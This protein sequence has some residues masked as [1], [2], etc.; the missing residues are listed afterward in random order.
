[1]EN[2]IPYL[3][4][5]TIFLLIGW[6]IAV[7]TR[8]S[9]ILTFLVLLSAG[10]VLFANSAYKEL[11]FRHPFL[12]GYLGLA[13]GYYRNPR[14][15]D[16]SY[17][18]NFSAIDIFITPIKSAIGII[19]I[20]LYL[21]F[22][23][24][25]IFSIRLIYWLI[26]IFKT[27]SSVDGWKNLFWG[28]W[29][30]LIYLIPQEI[31]NEWNNTFG[32]NRTGKTYSRTRTDY[33]KPHDQHRTYDRTHTDQH[34]QREQEER[35]C[36]EY[37]KA[38]QER[39]QQESHRAEQQAKRARQAQEQADS[40]AKETQ[41]KQYEKQHSNS[42]AEAGWNM[43]NFEEENE[44]FF[45]KYFNAHDILGTT[46]RL[47]KAQKRKKYHQLA[48]KYMTYCQPYQPI[49]VQDRATE[50]MKRINQAKTEVIG[51]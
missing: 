8:W 18:Y 39:R 47:T 24:V 14:L 19:K 31:R 51:K 42:F 12:Y 3:I 4:P 23:K 44:R 48:K 40:R 20:L 5:F 41:Q 21:V 13:W 27:L 7:V 43:K 10:Y 17:R 34:S 30:W 28:L 29:Q 50:I 26:H 9:K 25:P 49:A 33:K 22:I 16:W 15:K 1:M 6:G 36:R 2:L 38:E 11:H 37:Q 32:K 35:Q 46:I 45:N